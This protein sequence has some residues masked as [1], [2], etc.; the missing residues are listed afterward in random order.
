MGLRPGCGGPNAGPPGAPGRARANQRT[1]QRPVGGAG[2]RPGGGAAAVGAAGRFHPDADAAWAQFSLPEAL[3]L[4][5]RLCRDVRRDA[6]RNIP[7][8]RTMRLSHLLWVHRQNERYGAAAQTG[9]RIGYGLWRVVR[10]VLN[11]LQ[12][13]G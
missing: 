5:E 11:P 8:V 12:A 2:A 1:P 6:L 10:A 4:A 9:W 7:G 13:A 3:L